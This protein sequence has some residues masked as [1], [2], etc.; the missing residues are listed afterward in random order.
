[1]TD[2]RTTPKPISPF[3]FVA[4]DNNGAPTSNKIAR[5]VII[6]TTGHKKDRFTGMLACTADGGKLPAFVMLKRKAMPKD[7]FPASIIVRVQQK[8]WMDKGLVQDWV[9]MVWSSRLDG[10]LSR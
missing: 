8:G 4:G 6:N 9:R 1:M 10:S 2:G 5:N 3:H 7:K